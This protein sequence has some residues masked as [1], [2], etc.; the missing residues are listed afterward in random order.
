MHAN[1]KHNIIDFNQWM[2][3]SCQFENDMDVEFEDTY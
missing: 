2:A 1:W 3:E